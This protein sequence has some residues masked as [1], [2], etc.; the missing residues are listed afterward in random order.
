MLFGI[1]V[2]LR[3]LQYTIHRRITAILSKAKH[4]LHCIAVSE[5]PRSSVQLKV[6]CKVQQHIRIATL[7]V[8][9]CA[10]FRC[11]GGGR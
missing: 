3:D 9:Q 10:Y 2:S 7:D 8:L 11:K 1:S 5:Q 4:S 6:V